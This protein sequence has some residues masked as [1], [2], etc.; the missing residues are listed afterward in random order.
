MEMEGIG[1]RKEV[2]YEL[3]ALK[4]IQKKNE[5]LTG[6]IELKSLEGINII[7]PNQEDCGKRIKCIFNSRSHVNCLVYGM[8]Q[9]GKT[10]C[11]TAVIQHYILSYNIPI[12]N[13]Y[14]ITG[15]SDKEWKKDTKNRMPDS[16][17]ARVFHRANL[18]TFIRDIN[19]KQNC[20]IIM[21]EIQI[22]CVEDQTIF[23]TFSE[24]RFYDLDFLLLNDIKL[25]QFSATPDGNMKDIG[26]WKHHSAKVKLEPGEGYYGPKQAIEQN[27]VKQYNDLT[28][29][30]NV[31]ELKQD[32]ERNFKTPRYH[33][34]RV[35]NK[36]ENK[37]GTNNQ[38]KVISNIKKVFG[39][40]YE[41]NKNYLKTKKGDI[42]ETLK[43][44][45][46]KHTFIFYCE[47]LRCAKTQY[48]KYIGISYERYVPNPIDSSIIQGS[49]G[50]LT[51]YDDN[52]DS[53]CYTNIPSLEK[54][55]QLWENN[56]E[57][58][59]GIVWNTKTTH[60]DEK[61][62]ITYSTGTFNSVKNIE[63][64]KDGCSEK[65]KE[66]RG[67]PT[68]K[69]FYGEAGQVEGMGYFKDNLKSKLGGKGPNKTK[70][71][72]NGYYIRPIGK[73]ND[74]KNVLSTGKMFE[75]RRWNLDGNS[76]K[77]R[78]QYTWFPCYSDI[79]DPNTL[80]W[81]LIYYEN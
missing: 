41:Y 44:Q 73:G 45:P 10:G 18:K 49:L 38:S 68:I 31:E 24:C 37:D 32:I 52:S 43:K 34:V 71:N 3:K 12:D 56:M 28:N 81:W 29:I 36:R 47:I 8:T 62:D 54:Y 61:D 21:D 11:M 69:K 46:E 60:Y 22:A 42:N 76:S 6:Q 59:E 58:K 30:D 64:L 5:I 35:P 75:H 65:V 40:N 26:D 53:I 16:I 50:R 74:R 33:L 17:S 39:E 79:N 14:I 77:K 4:I 1:Q 19:G 63:Q 51:G 57:F 23:K 7:Y 55:I 48:K 27:R 67:E 15:L 72:E 13:I 20:L 66:D 70:I 2:D 80:E 25:I 78:T 9:T